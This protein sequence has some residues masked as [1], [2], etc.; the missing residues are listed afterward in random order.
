MQIRFV[1]FDID[2]TLLGY[3]PGRNPLLAVC[4]QAGG[5]SVV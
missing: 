2:G 5:K 3:A 4:A 1:F